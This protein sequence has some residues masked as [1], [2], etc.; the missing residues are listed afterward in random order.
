MHL[1][2]SQ[3]KHFVVREENGHKV[4]Y[5][6]FNA[7]DQLGA[8]NATKIIEARQQKAFTSQEDFRTRTKINHALFDNLQKTGVFAKI[9]VSSQAQ[10]NF[11]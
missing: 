1:E 8:E 3:D 7:V 10:F 5:P 11:E 4:I 2:H 9:P 6:P